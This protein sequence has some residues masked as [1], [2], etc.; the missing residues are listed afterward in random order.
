[1]IVTTDSAMLGRALAWITV[2]PTATPST[3]TTAMLEF[4]GIV[5][6]DGTL[7]TA[8]CRSGRQRDRRRRGPR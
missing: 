4:A 3:G 7:A 1:M 5:T 6:V 8:G 2:L